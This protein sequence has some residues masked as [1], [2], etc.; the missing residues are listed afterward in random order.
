MNA[1]RFG[2]VEGMNDDVR[3]FGVMRMSLVAFRLFLFS[4]VCFPF[5]FGT[6]TLRCALPC[7]PFA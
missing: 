2:E 4:F 3:P 6:D 7:V 5:G 1:I